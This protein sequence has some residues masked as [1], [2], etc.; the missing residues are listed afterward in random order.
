MAKR[1]RKRT[2][3][4]SRR[5]RRGFF[6]PRRIAAAVAAV[7]M[8]LM[9]AYAAWLDHRVTSEFE[10]GRWAVPARVYARP[11]ELF[12]GRALSP[13]NFVR[14]LQAADYHPGGG[15][16][17]GTYVRRNDTFRLRTR[18]FR[19]W[20]GAEPSH[21]LEVR[22][23]GD[24][25]A[26]VRDLAQG[27]SLPLVRLDPAHIG[28]IYPNHRED[29]ILV[30]LDDVPRTLVEA[31]IAVEDH[32]FM[33]HHGV[34]FIG[35]ARA[36][37]ANLRAGR[38]VQGGSTLTQ[39]LVKNYFLSNERTLWRKLNEAAMAVLLELH[40]DKR[41]ILQ[42][43]LNEIYLGQDGNRS[44]NGF[45]LASRFYFGRSLDELDLSQQ[46]LL[47]GLVRGPSY[48][49]PRRHPERARKRRNLVLDVMADQGYADR[50]AIRAAKGEDIGVT[51]Q[52]RDSNTSYPA[53]M[54]LVK[55]H[56]SRDY[57]PEDL[58]SEGLRIFTT[59]APSVQQSAEAAVTRRAKAWMSGTQA[60]ALVVNVDDGE[61][62]AVVGGTD[63]R[64]A[65]FN[66]ALDARRPVGSL[67][68]PAIY[69][70]AFERPDRYGLGTLIED[71]PVTLQNASGQRWT[72]RNY[73]R[74]RHGEVPLWKA[75][76]HSYNVPTVRLGLD[77]GLRAV[78][79]TV[80]RLGGRVP[81]TVY[82]SL[83]LG[84]LPLSPLEVAQM[85][86]TL[87]GGG[88]RTPLRAVRAVMTPQGRLLSRYS[89]SVRRVAESGPAYLVKYA[90][91]RVVEE[92]TARG[93]AHW[94]DDSTVVAGKTGTTDDT[95]DSWFAGFSG[96]TLGV[97]WVGRDDNGKTG[98]TGSSGAMTVFGELFSR[99]QV[100]PL[101][102]KPP[103]GVERRW[104]DPDTGL[105]AAS[106][107]D[108]AVQLPYVE[109]GAPTQDAPCVRGA[110]VV[111]RASDWIRRLFN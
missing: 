28:N 60:A 109:G 54:D 30:R 64:F 52:P 25:V 71:K 11:L 111:D 4:K 29:R 103:E 68:K 27:A 104:V 70:T 74:E 6:R 75:L 40:Y 12:A 62:Q 105:A 41:A 53:F 24:R 58:S 69:L 51:P 61:V 50:Q 45:G 48:Y 21:R 84:A 101:D 9:A 97:V 13:G 88:F 56:L 57:E 95:R 102:L 31:L 108:G 93:L 89:L 59:L 76:A 16:A 44:I 36:A 66:R 5:Q 106:Y 49:D 72:P 3:R 1:P 22:F 38:V 34:S 55:R 7:G 17:P 37:L 20:D 8:M 18:S 83:L 99:L 63:P 100:R 78:V 96:D 23:S 32:R 80:Q 98:L 110:N 107:C 65:G 19:F 26:A 82:P 91:R 39:Q 81:D 15:T 33:E 14:E 47:V 90:M 10:G 2:A 35:I 77:V 67:I 79:D 73:D 94:L 86:E 87:A 85:Y 46:A 92:G 42:A 43:Y